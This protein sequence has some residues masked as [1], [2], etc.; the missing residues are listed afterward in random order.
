MH[1][2][3]EILLILFIVLF[4]AGVGRVFSLRL[5]LPFVIGEILIGVII[6]PSVLGLVHPSEFL[7]VLSELG[8]I[9]LLF[10]VGLETDIRAMVKVGLPSV[11]A[12]T[13]GVILPF[14]GGFLFAQRF[15]LGLTEAAFFGTALVA[16]SVGITSKVLLELNALKE[17]YSGVILGA[18]VLDD[19]LAMLLLAVVLG[20]KTGGGVSPGEILVPL[21]IALLFVALFMFGVPLLVKKYLK[22]RERIEFRQSP[23]LPVITFLFGLSAL[24]SYIGLAAIIGAFLAGLTVSELREYYRIE[25]EVAPIYALFSPFFFVFIGLQLDVR[26]FL[27][28]ETLTLIVL[29]T[30]L[31]I[32]TKLVGAALGALALGRREAIIIGVG[33]VPRGEVGILV[34]GLGL[35]LKVISMD[36]FSIV[37]AMSILTTLITPPVLAYLINKL[38]EKKEMISAPTT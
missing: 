21:L 17:K 19:I 15:E 2:A 33:M 31:A 34:A 23:I 12:G 37:V 18:A 26:V 32:V 5:G 35:N 6:G 38:R 10:T 30:I 29:I 22:E 16:T 9:F 11:M 24:S 25:E 27:R 1:E 13:L 4:A 7:R 36:V 20:F 28:S 14:F 8:A 3:G